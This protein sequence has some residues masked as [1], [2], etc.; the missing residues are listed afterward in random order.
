MDAREERGLVIAATC[1]LNRMSDG[2]WL[3]PSQTKTSEITAYHVNLETKTCTCL[4]HTEGKNTCK[5]YFAASIVHKRDVL[6]DGTVI[7]QKTFAFT[8]KKVYRQDWPRYNAA[9]A[10]EKKR[11]RILLHDLCKGLPVRERAGD[12]KGRNPHQPCDGVFAM[13]YKVYCGLSARRFTTDLQEAYDMGFISKTMPGMKAT[14]CAEDPYYTPILK[15][16]VGYSA[17]P[18]RSLETEFAIDSSGFGSTKYEKWYDHKYGITRNRCVWVKTHI[19]SGIR[20]NVVTAVRIL[21]K[22][23]ADS[24]QFIPLVKETKKHFEVSEISA[25][26]AYASYENFEAVAECGAQ[27]FIAFKSNTTGL[28]GG[29]FEKAFHYFQYNQEEYMA[30]YHKRSN[31]EST[32]SAIKRKFGADVVSKN[33]VAMVNEVLCK[34]ICH[35]ITCLIHEQENLGIVPVFWKDEAD[36]TKALQLQC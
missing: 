26:K 24:P 28:R 31:V 20:T 5:H 4:D 8:E 13:C 14:G 9:Q 16:L 11:F 29:M 15:A 35:N 21:D 19:A 18:L 33:P 2:T 7:E 34:L 6:P 36:A 25:D 30:H 3:V 22:D 17:R 12:W 32:F 1:R 23:A 27:A 10:S